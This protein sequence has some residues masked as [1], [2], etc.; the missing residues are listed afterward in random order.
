MA[1]ASRCLGYES[2]S[3]STVLAHDRVHPET[4]GQGY[5]AFQTLKTKYES[6]KTTS[7]ETLTGG[8]EQRDLYRT[9]GSI[10]QDWW[11]SWSASNSASILQTNR[12]L[13]VIYLTLCTKNYKQSIRN[14]KCFTIDKERILG[15]LKSTTFP[16]GLQHSLA[17]ICETGR[18]GAPAKRN[19]QTPATSMTELGE[20]EEK[21]SR[22]SRKTK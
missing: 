14:L 12:T 18:S 16:P 13:A 9:M 1:V 17:I 22:R 2:P 7:P 11:R 20:R 6:D 19:V 10:Q 4:K 5:E 15:A 8:W 21:R 3:V